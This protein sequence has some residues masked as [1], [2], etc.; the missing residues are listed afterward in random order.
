MCIYIAHTH[1]YM[2]KYIYVVEPVPSST[3]TLPQDPNTVCTISVSMYVCMYH[4]TVHLCVP[5]DRHKNIISL[6]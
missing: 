1:V 4:L 2:Y 5:Y 6:I 3:Y